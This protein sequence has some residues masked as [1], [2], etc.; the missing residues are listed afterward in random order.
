[1]LIPSIK[2]NARW[3]AS[4]P[5]QV[6]I[7]KRVDIAKA[8]DDR[9]KMLVETME[10]RKVWHNYDVSPLKL[11]RMP[12]VQM[13]AFFTLFLAIRSLAKAP[14]PQFLTGGFGWVQ[15][16]SVPDPYYILPATSLIFTMAV[17]RV[18]DT[19]RT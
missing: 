17:I 14:W 4:M 9:Q 1:M 2:H 10:I 5:E 11:V 8:K 16:L 6:E 13:G 18:S 12:F 7:Q 15:D 3:S 19:T